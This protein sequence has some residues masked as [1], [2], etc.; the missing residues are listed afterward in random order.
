MKLL[1]KVDK[2]ES[3]VCLIQRIL[4]KHFLV[5]ILSINLLFV[6]SFFKE[7]N[8]AFSAEIEAHGMCEYNELPEDFKERAR[9]ARFLQYR[10]F[11]SD[12]IREVLDDS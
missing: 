3:S 10:G 12:Q 4:I 1:K 11:T 6:F 7:N 2:I 9:Q 5:S 8:I